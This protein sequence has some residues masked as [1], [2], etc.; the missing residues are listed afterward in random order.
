[1]RW[2]DVTPTYTLSVSQLA[3]RLRDFQEGRNTLLLPDFQ[4]GSRV[5]FTPR[6]CLIWRADF[7][8]S[9]DQ[10][11]DAPWRKLAEF[12]KSPTLGRSFS[13]ELVQDNPW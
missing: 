9:L 7:A 4:T 12:F 10:Q 8:Y 5:V 2:I 3:Q 13:P 11:T 1:M 6:I